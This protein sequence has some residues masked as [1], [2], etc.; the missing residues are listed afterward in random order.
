MAPILPYTTEEA[1]S[2]MPD[3]QGK[4][5]SV[6]LE[7]FSR[8]QERFLAEETYQEWE[9][10]SAVRDLVLKQLELAR[11]SKLIG[12]SL[13]ASA[14]LRVPEQLQALLQKYSE[15]L[16]SLFIVSNVTL[17][18]TSEEELGIQVSKV[19]W[20]KCQRCW[21]YSDYVGTSS[22]YPIFCQRCEDVVKKMST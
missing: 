4:S 20:E 14:A 21:N 6:H 7:L 8:F 3:F 10:L 19:K 12:N 15:E 1:W 5:E 22:D 16:P 13:E 11:E 18:E 17:E 9:R 2:A